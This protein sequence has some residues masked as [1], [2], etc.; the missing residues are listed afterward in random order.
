MVMQSE[1]SDSDVELDPDNLIGANEITKVHTV[2]TVD[3]EQ[4]WKEA[5]SINGWDVEFKLDTG[6]QVK[7][8]P[9]YIFKKQGQHVNVNKTKVVHKVFGGGGGLE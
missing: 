2:E 4:T 5:I 3:E 6:S 1:E 8:I 9:L 7:L